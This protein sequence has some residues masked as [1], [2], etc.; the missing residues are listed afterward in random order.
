MHLGFVQDHNKKDISPVYKLQRGNRKLGYD[1]MISS[2]PKRKQGGYKGREDGGSKDMK[3]GC[4]CA[5][6]SVVVIHT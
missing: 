6:M 5:C 1:V 2:K 4:R 3:L